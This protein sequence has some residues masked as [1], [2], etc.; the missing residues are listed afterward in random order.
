MKPPAKTC[1]ER[2]GNLFTRSNPRKRITRQKEYKRKQFT[3]DGFTVY[4]CNQ[5]A[6]ELAAWISSEVSHE[7]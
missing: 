7:A 4:L 2:C 3:S 6:D 1:C 5:C